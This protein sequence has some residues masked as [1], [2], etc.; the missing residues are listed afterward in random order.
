MEVIDLI[1]KLSNEEEVPKKII[2]KGH[3]FELIEDYKKYN[4]NYAYEDESENYWLDNAKLGEEV[5]II[6]EDKKIEPLSVLANFEVRSRNKFLD[7]VLTNIN[8]RINEII[9][10]QAEIIKVLNESKKGK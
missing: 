1:I 2:I 7:S 10:K 6:E 4:I 5:E 3:M 9:L 8:Y